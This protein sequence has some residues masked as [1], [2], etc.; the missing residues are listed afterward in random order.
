MQPPLPFSSLLYRYF[1]FEWLF[2]DV[3]CGNVWQDAAAWRHNKAQAHWL[4]TYIRRW[5]VLCVLM[6]GV[7]AF[8]ETVL[9]SPILSVF[10]YVAVALAVPYNAVAGLCWWHLR[11]GGH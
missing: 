2:K 9:G 6:F 8:C 10:F 4:L 11:F 3:R 5:T 7:A 1:F